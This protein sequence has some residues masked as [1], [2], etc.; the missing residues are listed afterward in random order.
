MSKYKCNQCNKISTSEE[1]NEPMKD[2]EDF[3]SIDDATNA[4]E[5]VYICP[6]CKE[7]FINKYF[8]KQ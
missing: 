8:L 5:F 3:V 1:I 2:Q 4:D 6:H 7:E